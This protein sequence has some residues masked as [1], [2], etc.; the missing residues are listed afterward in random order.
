MKKYKKLSAVEQNQSIKNLSLRESY[1]PSMNST[2]NITGTINRQNP[3]LNLR[4][5]DN[6]QVTTINTITTHKPI[7]TIRFHEKNK[8]I[9]SN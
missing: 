2:F 5:S 8:E 4:K 3:K 1:A 9:P 7:K 6:P